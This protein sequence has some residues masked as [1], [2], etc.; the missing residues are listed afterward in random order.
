[1]ERE[2]GKRAAAFD[3]LQRISEEGLAV[4]IVLDISSGSW[5]ITVNARPGRPI[6]LERGNL[7]EAIHAMEDALRRAWANDG[8]KKDQ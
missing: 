4:G 6:T 2:R 1:M 5:K 8:P 7:R 3:T